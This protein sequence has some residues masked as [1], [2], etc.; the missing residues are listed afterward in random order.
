[1]L[2]PLAFAVDAVLLGYCQ[3]EAAVPGLFEPRKLSEMDQD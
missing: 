3:F 2:G 1:M